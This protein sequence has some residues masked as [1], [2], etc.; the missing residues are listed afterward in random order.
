MRKR[1]TDR[2]RA[3]STWRV[4]LR[5]GSDSPGAHRGEPGYGEPVPPYAERQRRLNDASRRSATL[6]AWR[7][8]E[9]LRRTAASDLGFYVERYEVPWNRINDG[10]PTLWSAAEARGHLNAWARHDAVPVEA[11][12]RALLY[13]QQR[14]LGD[15]W[16]R[17]ETSLTFDDDGM[18]ADDRDVLAYASADGHGFVRCDENHSEVSNAVWSFVLHVDDGVKVGDGCLDPTL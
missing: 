2:R 7:H 9:R 13:E 12:L 17:Y 15:Q 3:T 11:L 5:L 14:M 8:M 1:E 10:D 16:R 18:R 6:D 4:V